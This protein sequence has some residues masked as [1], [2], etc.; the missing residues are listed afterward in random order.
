M[1]T[2]T[3]IPAIAVAVAFSGI[4]TSAQA[5]YYVLP[6]SQLEAQLYDPNT[7]TFTPQPGY[8]VS[9]G[10][11]ANGAT[12]KQTDLSDAQGRQAFASVD[13]ANGELKVRA[14][15]S[16]GTR[17]A[18]ANAI[19]GDTVTIT[20]GAGTYWDFGIGLD[21]F[22][23]LE[24]GSPNASV[25]PTHGH[26]NYGVTLAIY[27]P[28][29]TIFH[30]WSTADTAKAVFFRSI[31]DSIDLAD[32]YISISEWIGD[33]I[34]LGG[35]TE[36][37]EIYARIVTG[38]GTSTFDG[39]TSILGD[40]SQTATL[41]FNFDSNVTP[42]ADSGVLLGL[43]PAPAV[44]EPETYALMLAGLGLVGLVAARRRKVGV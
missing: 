43:G 27:R 2:R 30:T 31:N 4:V 5:D 38:V 32:S 29:V 10:F 11:E 44:P 28:G 1:I 26:A 15:A 8:Q 3:H 21:G 36:T 42:Y 9:N 37:F 23:E 7:G 18:S 22:F 39:I 40:F 16:G 19:F 33:S 14:G 12:F 6:Y 13:L 24:F 17:S 41:E 34:L 35:N 25:P 20:G